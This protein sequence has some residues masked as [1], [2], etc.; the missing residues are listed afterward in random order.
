MM[1]NREVVLMGKVDYFTGT[2]VKGWMTKE[3]MRGRHHPR[4]SPAEA[5]EAALNAGLA[6]ALG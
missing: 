4:G 5:S 1:L 3:L 2:G 6:P